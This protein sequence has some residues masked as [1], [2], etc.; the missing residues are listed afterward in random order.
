MTV[1]HEN[2][3]TVLRTK[4]LPANK[5][6]RWLCGRA[7]HCGC[8]GARVRLPLARE[9]A[10]CTGVSCNPDLSSRAGR[11]LP[12]YV[13]ICRDAG[14]TAGGGGTRNSPVTPGKLRHQQQ[15]CTPMS[16]LFN[17][18]VYNVE[19][20]YCS[21]SGRCLEII[22]KAGHPA[23]RYRPKRH[24][25]KP[26]QYTDGF[27]NMSCRCRLQRRPK[28]DL[29]NPGERTA[30]LKSTHCNH[31]EFSDLSTCLPYVLWV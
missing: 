29:W 9:T 12:T 13:P 7:P 8:G 3:K 14:R 1:N 20:T 10:S 4:T 26:G 5:H 18:I 27:P 2:L 17:S 15:L 11:F 30:I 28:W 25:G 21:P 16:R 31:L 19:T 24:G 22:W 23:F 6:L